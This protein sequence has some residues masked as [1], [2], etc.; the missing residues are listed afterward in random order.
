MYS[1]DRG[2]LRAENGCHFPSSLPDNHDRHL[3]APP[4]VVVVCVFR[5]VVSCRWFHAAPP[6]LAVHPAV[7]SASPRAFRFTR[8]GASYFVVRRFPCRSSVRR[9]LRCFMLML[10]TH[11]DGKSTIRPFRFDLKKNSEPP[12]RG[13][14]R[15]SSVRANER[16]W[17]RV[18]HVASGAKSNSPPVRKLS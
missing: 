3:V 5:G 15:G 17:C 2:S 18:L 14:T 13:C 16:G 8:G 12:A 9:S 6:P 7:A 10:I 11:D 4:L 1:G